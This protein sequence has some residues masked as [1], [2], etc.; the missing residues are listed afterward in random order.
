MAIFELVAVAGKLEAAARE[1]FARFSEGLALYREGHWTEAQA[2]FQRALA[3]Q[4]ADGPSQ[5]FAARCAHYLQHQ[6]ER[7]DG[8]HVM[9]T[10]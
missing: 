3:L 1:L 10:K 5:V 9:H 7:W 2:A 4:P 6:P 8:V